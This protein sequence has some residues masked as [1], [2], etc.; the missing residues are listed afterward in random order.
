MYRKT[1]A[2]KNLSFLKWVWTALNLGH[3]LIMPLHSIS[4][5]NLIITPALITILLSI[6]IFLNPM[7][8]CY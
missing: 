6:H 2:A 8:L 3:T 5:L 7:S 4:L 1:Y